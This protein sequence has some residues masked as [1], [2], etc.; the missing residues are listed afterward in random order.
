MAWLL[1]LGAA[2]YSDAKLHPTS[3]LLCHW[4]CKL[5]R[6]GFWLDC[7]MEMILPELYFGALQGQHCGREGSRIERRKSVSWGS[8]ST[9]ASAGTTE[10]S[11]ARMTLR[12]ALNLGPLPQPGSTNG[13]GVPWEKGVTLGKA[14]LFSQAFPE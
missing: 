7:E 10:N 6:L 3:V 2:G 13:C 8:V 9:E 1:V 5:H 11:E 14:V 4:W 12:V